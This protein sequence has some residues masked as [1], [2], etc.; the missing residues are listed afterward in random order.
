MEL[1]EED[2]RLEAIHGALDP[3]GEVVDEEPDPDLDRMEAA[4]S[5][6]VRATAPLELSLIHISEPT[7]PH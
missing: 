7:R 6:I 5:L 3:E 1:P 2:P 4:V